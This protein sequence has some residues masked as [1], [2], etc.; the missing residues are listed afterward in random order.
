MICCSL[1]V[2]AVA[3]G[4]IGWRRFRRFLPGAARAQSLLAAGAAAAVVITITALSGEH[5]RHHAAHASGPEMAFGDP[6]PLCN[7]SDRTTNIASN[8][9]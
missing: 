9:D 6:L 8:E 4:A 5:F 1:G 3:T 7:G 2:A